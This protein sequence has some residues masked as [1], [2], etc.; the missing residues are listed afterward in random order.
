N[1]FDA[2]LAQ[3]EHLVCHK[4]PEEENRTAQNCCQQNSHMFPLLFAQYYALIPV[5]GEGLPGDETSTAFAALLKDLKT[6]F[7]VRSPAGC[8]PQ[9][10]G[11]TSRPT[12]GAH[13]GKHFRFCVVHQIRSWREPPFWSKKSPGGVFCLPEK[14]DGQTPYRCQTHTVR[15][16]HLPTIGY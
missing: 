9:R 13:R 7:L 6:L 2:D 12:A 15:S 3:A 4:T 1:V 8:D 11:C 14:S 10:S 16:A 5:F